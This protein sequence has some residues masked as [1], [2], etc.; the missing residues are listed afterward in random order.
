ILAG[1]LMDYLTFWGF[2]GAPGK[3]GGSGT[4]GSKGP[5]G[6]V[7][8]PG[9]TG[10]RGEPGP[11]M[12]SF[13][14]VVGAEG[15]P[16]K[17]G[18]VGARVSHATYLK[19]SQQSTVMHIFTLFNLLITRETG[20]TLVQRDCRVLEGLQELRDLFN[21]YFC[22]VCQ[23]ANGAWSKTVVEYRTQKS[24]RLPI[25]DIAPMDIGRDD[26]EFGLDVG[27]VCFS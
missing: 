10:P 19:I 21:I 7:G 20:V 26:Q 6:G 24:V 17:D 4:P 23:T 13:Q 8:L 3:P 18:L 1:R 14:G 15:G 2:Q 22:F 11:E 25:V 5:A 12:W 16:G 27:P 9:A